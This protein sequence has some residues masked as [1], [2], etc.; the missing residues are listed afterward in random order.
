MRP[1]GF[2]DVIVLMTAV[3]FHYAGFALPLLAGLVARELGGWLARAVDLGVIAGGAPG[4][5]R[6]TDSMVGRGL[7]PLHL[8]ELVAS[9]LLAA[10]GLLVGLL[11]LQLAARPGRP[12]V[13]R[14]LMA[15]AGLAPSGPMILA[16]LYALGSYTGHA[17]IGVL[18]MI[19]THGI[20][21]ALGFALLGLLAWSLAPA[22]PAGP[23]GRPREGRRRGH[24]HRVWD[25]GA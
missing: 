24:A 11:H 1:L 10:S 23:A 16:G 8:L 22:R 18:G 25:P 19:H 17:R 5:R 13:V 15:I 12:A 14:A 21:N 6:I 3:H 20:A 4:G 2:P 7:L 9:W